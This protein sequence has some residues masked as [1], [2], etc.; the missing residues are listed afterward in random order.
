M[1][2]KV[3][4]I[5]PFY[6]DPYIDE[7]VI[8]ALYQTYPNIEVIVIDDGSTQ[9]Q[10]KLAPYRSRIHYIGKANGGT[11]SALNY[12][13][14]LATGKYVAWLSS[15]DRFMPDK[16]TKQV[17]Y[18]ERM[19]AQIS[20]TDFDIMNENSTVIMRSAAAKY[21][22]SK[23][24]ITALKRV[25]PVNGCTIMMTKDLIQSMGW[26]NQSLP[27]THDYDLWIRVVLAQVDFHFINEALTVYRRHPQM[28]TIKHI[29]T[30]K[31]EAQS[32]SDLYEGRLDTLLAQ[33]PG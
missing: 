3:S 9:H 32:I 17:A 12:G 31:I 6:N 27:Y 14:Q 18:M 30:I 5:I 33:L 4:I 7:A 26:F 11:A 25:C 10:S 16:I 24:F 28:G 22:T 15:D 13:M 1:T 2:P 19:N 20:H 29:D 23:A 8:S 21:P